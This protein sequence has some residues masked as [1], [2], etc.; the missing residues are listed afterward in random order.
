MVGGMAH[1]TPVPRPDFR[2]LGPVEVLLAGTPVP[3]P[4]G[5]QRTLLAMLLLSRGRAVTIDRLCDGLWGEE[6]P[7]DPRASLHTTVARLRRTLGPAGDALRTVAPG[8]ALDS[9]AGSFDSDRFS[10]L[11]RRGRALLEETQRQG[12]DV[13]RVSE[14]VQALSSALDL[15][16]GP[17]WAEFADGVASG[18]ALR[19]EEERLAA[20]EDLAAALVAADRSGEAVAMLESLVAENPLRDRAVG[21]LVDA[22]HR[23]GRT[24]D[25]LAVYGAYRERLADEL[26]LDPSPALAALQQRVLRQEL[27]ERT[28]GAG[29]R[30]FASVRPPP[31]PP[32]RRLVGRDEE[33]DA[34]TALLGEM[35]VVTLVGTGGVGKT[36]LARHVAERFRR[37]FFWVDLAPVRDRAGVFQAVADALGVD[38]R[39]DRDLVTTVQDRLA[40]E[41]DLVVLDNCEHVLDG[42]ATLL[43]PSSSP[44]PFTVLATSRERLGVHG[45]RVFPVEPL[46]LPDRG[47]ADAQAPAVA[48]FL[49]R[50]RDAG[51]DLFGDAEAVRRVGEVCRALDGLP[52][53]LE[54]G[55]ARMG[56]LTLDDLADRLDHRFDLLTRGPRTAPGRHRTLRSV[57][58]W[59]YDLLE[60]EERTVFTRLAVFPAG[61]DLDAA[62]AVVGDGT[63]PMARVADVVAQLADRSMVVRPT[64][65]GRG[66][67]RL[68]E[69]LRQY[70]ASRLS[71]EELADARRRHAMWALELAER[72]RIG[73]EGPQ[74]ER[75]SR[76]LDDLLQDLRSA[77]R[78]TREADERE[79]AGRLVAATWRWAHWRLRAD[80]LGW[81]A[82]LL[83]AYPA[84]APVV[85]YTAAVGRAWVV[86]DLVEAERV[87]ALAAER[88]PDET[89][90]ADVFEILGD[91]HLARSAVRAA[92][93]SYTRAAKAHEAL[94]HRVSGAV[95]RSNMVLALAYAGQDAGQSLNQALAAAAATGNPTAISFARYVEAESCV[96]HDERLAQAA[97]E[98]AIR[99]AERVGNRLVSGVAM[100][101]LV[102]LRGRS[103]PVTAETFDLFRRV[104]EHWTTTR[105]TALL[106]TALRNLVILLGR[107]ARDE[108]AVELWAALHAIDS[109]H[110]SYGIE[111]ERLET[112]V[113]AA[114]EALG[115]YFD[116]AVLRGR[117][118][119]GL[120]AVAGLAERLCA[121]EGADDGDSSSHQART[122]LEEPTTASHAASPDARHSSPATTAP[123]GPPTAG[124]L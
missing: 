94:G 42:V 56:S 109:E 96:E 103:A 4:A 67:Y 85:A 63:L 45:E 115:P 98:E 29:D 19:L 22:L 28:A 91:V 23:Y 41:P 46:R 5:A 37:P 3:V 84:D 34:V 112:A 89:A 2:I 31:Q 73:L 90:R 106:V 48:L 6:Q 122:R 105:S 14:A 1:E 21:L 113:A 121:T 64:G 107:A 80:V 25:A 39:A 102:A 40:A 20:Q 55:A 66:R 8:Y 104:I 36:S 114:R 108:E 111:A 38:E 35:T 120:S 124:A 117:T 47:I 119:V 68:L 54:L 10:E 53:A 52:L 24:A 33:T 95:A 123:S 71:P 11:H 69:S 44:G 97:L 78:W 59:S 57:V 87:A 62:E 7:K 86:G 93:A 30:A 65:A 58:D 110:P 9:T 17:A 51:A 74:E 77:W 26:G 60:A 75:W 32:K 79:A 49:A 88:Y 82:Q 99:S 12:P 101:A 92:L 118:Y 76:L 50:A 13:A 83:A 27:P 81:G 72:G 15:W 70:A 116:D 18:D 100:T 16:R 43:S 61:F